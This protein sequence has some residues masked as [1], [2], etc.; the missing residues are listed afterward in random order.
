M[1]AFDSLES[2]IFLELV[3]CNILINY[4]HIVNSYITKFLFMTLVS[5][6]P[7]LLLLLE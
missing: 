2:I 5:L 7:F 6:T 3:I 4:V 1:C